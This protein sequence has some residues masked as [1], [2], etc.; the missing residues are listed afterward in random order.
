MSNSKLKNPVNITY[1]CKECDKT[2]TR[3]WCFDAHP[4]TKLHKDS[5]IKIKIKQGKVKK[6][7]E[8][9][10]A[11]A[12]NL[13]LK[14][15]KGELVTTTLI[16]REVYHHIL[17]NNA[18]YYLSDK[19]YARIEINGKKYYLHRYIYYEFYKNKKTKYYDVDHKNSI[20]LDN[21]IENLRETDKSG[22]ARNRV[23]IKNAT[24]KYY[25]VWKSGRL[26]SCSVKKDNKRYEF[27]Y[28]NELHAAYHRDL[29]I[30]ELGVQEFSKLNNIEKPKD[31]IMKEK[32]KRKNAD[33]PK[34]IYLKKN[35]YHYKLYDKRYFG[36]NTMVDAI[37][38]RN[39]HIKKQE[40][41][42]RI[43]FLAAGRASST[44]TPIL[45]NSDGNAIIEIF[46]RKRIKIAETIVSDDRY[47][48]INQYPWHMSDGYPQSKINGK[49]VRLS[50]YIIS[51]EN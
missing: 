1:Y 10:K 15:K 44:A 30:K 33:L 38:A 24:S 27:K 26:W 16:D 47:Y 39:E 11:T 20:P 32:F 3:K 6:K 41:A 31:F 29:L 12:F 18:T 46:N 21:R 35:K 19:R 45:R 42:K 25:G 36:Y 2:F 8:L 4:E 13:Q 49:H 34:G 14:N 9:K 43:Q 37:N 5:L 48:D 28:E 23:K 22:N 17:D 50:R 51:I 7:I 40:T